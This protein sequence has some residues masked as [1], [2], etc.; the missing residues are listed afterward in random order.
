[1]TDR[2]SGHA[3]TQP[4]VSG[5][6]VGFTAFAAVVM[7]MI[8]AFQAFQ[9]LVALLNDDFYVVG[10]KWVF[11]LDLTTWGWVHLIVGALVAVAGVFVLRGAVWARTVGVAVAAISALLNFMWLPYYPAWSLLIIALDIVVVWALIAHGRDIA[12]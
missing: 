4:P 9:G 12:R 8:G 11:S 6:A 10:Q 5:V 3:A 1:M 2:L 7:I